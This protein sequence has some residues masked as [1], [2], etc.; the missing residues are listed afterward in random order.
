MAGCHPLLLLLYFSS[1]ING[2]WQSFIATHQC[3]VPQVMSPALCYATHSDG[4]ETQVWKWTG[5]S[6]QCNIF[7]VIVEKKQWVLLAAGGAPPAQ[8]HRE[9]GKV[10][11]WRKVGQPSDDG[12]IMSSNNVGGQEEGR[13]KAANPR[14]S[15]NTHFCDHYTSLTV[16]HWENVFQKVVLHIPGFKRLLSQHSD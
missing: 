10:W 8:V 15:V 3:S 13:E 7:E 14:S 2:S 16:T 5:K 9:L 6:S 4:W 12:I 11:P 1:Y